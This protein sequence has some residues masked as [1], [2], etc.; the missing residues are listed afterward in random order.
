[1]DHLATHL[2]TLRQEINTLRDLNALY[3]QHRHHSPL[4]QTDFDVRESRLLQIKRELSN[5]LNSPPETS[6]W[7]EKSRRLTH[8]V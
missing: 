4:E 7:W 6:V 5:M 8:I 1:M 2:V 3:K